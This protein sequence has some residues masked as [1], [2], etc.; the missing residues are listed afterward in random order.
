MLALVMA[1]SAAKAQTLQQIENGQPQ[2]FVDAVESYIY[3]YPLM[4]VGVTGR[5]ATT[6]PDAMT[7][8]GAAPLNQFG[9]ELRLPDATFKDVV[10]PST[11]TLYA[12]SFLNLAEEP[13]ILHIPYMGNRFF[14]LQMLD[15]W[16]NVSMKSP[17][18]RL[19][20]QEGDYALVGPNWNGQLPFGLRETI[21]MPTN[22][23]WIIGRI[24]T[25]GTQWD[26]NEVVQ[27]IYPGLT[28][29]PLS[30]FRRGPYTPP[31]DL[32]VQP[33]ADVKTTPLNQVAGM[34]ACAFFQNM[35]AMMIY[36]RPIAGQDDAMLPK[37][38]NVGLFQDHYYDCTAIGRDTMDTLQKGVA[39]ARAFLNIAPTPPQTATK[40]TM[41]LGVGTYGDNYLLRAEVAKDA[42]GAN[43]PID[44][45]YGYT[46]ND[47]TNALLDG[48]NNYK[49]HFAP[50]GVSQGIPPVNPKG[51]WSV[52]I[53]NA[54]G[55]LV[56]NDAATN[57]GVNYNAIGVPYV[58]GHMAQFNMDGSLDLYLQTNPP[59]AGTAFKNWLPTPKTGN[60]IVFLRMYWPDQTIQSGQWIPPAIV[61]N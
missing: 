4:M 11:T 55:T 16:T 18:S 33:Y 21:Q 27:F 41:S 52:T 53:Y 36:N 47:G 19:G 9:K 35:A 15:G 37:L 12:S 3:G 7:K 25:N 45:V 40:W 30:R 57:A 34:D 59:P 32:P 58:Q 51:F 29:T 43:N 13:V 8:L 10:L 24:Y 46:T 54:D 49:I 42:L 23:M 56:A 28:L 6:V 17:G 1:G 26:L 22:T 39:A 20:S 60:Y 44:A 61:K 48:A 50:P 31:S 5:T 2:L 38:A 14:L